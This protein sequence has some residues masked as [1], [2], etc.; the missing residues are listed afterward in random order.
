[1]SAGNPGVFRHALTMLP[2]FQPGRG[3]A[4]I[5]LNGRPSAVA[6][7]FGSGGDA[8]GGAGGGAAGAGA[9]EPGAPDPDDPDPAACGSSAAVALVMRPTAP[10]MAATIQLAILA[11]VFMFPLLV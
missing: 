9:P 6:G 11:L 4:T 7:G 1:M 2:W 5:G 10:S 3:R 8:G